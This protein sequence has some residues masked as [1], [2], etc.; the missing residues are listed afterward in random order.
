[1]IVVALLVYPSVTI[2]QASTK[3]ET[4]RGRIVAYSND[5]ASVMCFDGVRQRSVL[6]HVEDP[7]GNMR[8]QFIQVQVSYSCKDLPKWFFRK[9]PDENFRLK[10]DGDLVLEEFIGTLDGEMP[11][12]NLVP[13]A[14]QEKIPFG[15]LVPNYRP[16]D[17][18]HSSIF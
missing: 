17:K 16:A 5:P 9:P 18:H 8:S 15:Q 4:I 1:M 10:R 6:I 3:V 14:V 7:Q 12:W 2:S 13:G 11:I